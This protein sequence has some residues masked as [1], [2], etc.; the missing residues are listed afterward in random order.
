MTPNM[1]CKQRL[2]QQQAVLYNGFKNESYKPFLLSFHAFVQR[3]SLEQDLEEG[4]TCD[5]CH[6]KKRFS[7]FTNSGTC[8]TIAV[9]KQLRLRE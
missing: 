7:F 6:K 1:I 9:T 8:G 5:F 2:D 3:H 4:E